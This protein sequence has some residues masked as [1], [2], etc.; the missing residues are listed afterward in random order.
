MTTQAPFC[1]YFERLF[2]ALFGVTERTMLVGGA[3][4]PFYRAATGPLTPHLIFYTADYIQSALHEV[5][6]W[7]IAGRARRAVD[8]YG[9]WYVPD[10]RDLQQQHAFEAVEVAPQAL[11]W[12]LSR[13][14]GQPFRVSADNL[15]GSVDTA[16]DFRQKVSARARQYLQQGLP[17]RA[18]RLARALDP[19][20]AYSRLEPY[21]QPAPR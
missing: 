4:E 6:H 12:I 21:L 14:A 5:A 19:G 15:A 20:G 3:V 9:Y 13:A 7:C 17:P 16:T 8:D 18:D 11:E 10:G 1:I 2:R